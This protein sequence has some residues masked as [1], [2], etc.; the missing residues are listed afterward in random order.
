VTGGVELG[1]YGERRADLVVM[2]DFIYAEPKVV[3]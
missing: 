2:D 1:P 3:K